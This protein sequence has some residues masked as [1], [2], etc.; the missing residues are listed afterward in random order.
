[1]DGLS[2]S[3]QFDERCTVARTWIACALKR[4]DR[5]YRLLDERRDGLVAGALLRIIGYT[6]Q[7]ILG[8]I[9]PGVGTVG[10]DSGR[11]QAPQCLRGRG[12]WPSSKLGKQVS[13][14]IAF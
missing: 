13:G 12:L 11:R 10:L 1:M 6:T 2:R 7:S 14:W 5:A 4:I 3:R 8:V 9:N